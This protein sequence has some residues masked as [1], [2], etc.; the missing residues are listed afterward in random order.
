MGDRHT[1]TKRPRENR[2]M[3]IAISA[4]LYSLC[5]IPLHYFSAFAKVSLFPFRFLLLQ[6]QE[7]T[8]SA[9]SFARSWLDRAKEA[10]RQGGNVTSHVMRM[11]DSCAICILLLIFSLLF[12]R[13]KKTWNTSKCWIYDTYTSRSRT[14]Q[15]LGNVVHLLNTL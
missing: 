14:L 9:S 7:L 6:L 12:R 2:C 5:C 15:F 10:A 4:V 3:I 11:I 1:T 8:S 13:Q